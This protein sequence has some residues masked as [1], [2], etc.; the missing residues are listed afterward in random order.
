MAI[1][2]VVACL[3]FVRPWL[4]GVVYGVYTTPMLWIGIPVCVGVLVLA[5]GRIDNS[6]A[7]QAVVVVCIIGVMA[8]SS[9]SGTFA[10]NTLGQ[11]TMQDSQTVDQLRETNASNPRLLTK[12]VADRYAT[13]TL[14]FPQYQISESD[15]TIHNGTPHW[16]YAL[17]PDGLWNHLTKK[18]HGTVMVDMTRQNAGVETI[19]NDLN[20][21]IGTAFYNNY[22][23]HLLKKGEY[24]ANYKD[25]FMVMHEGEQYIAVPYTVPK[26]HWLSIPHTTPTWGGVMLVDASGTVT[27]LSPEEARQHPA[28]KGQKL[29]PFD[30]TRRAV[31]A[32]KYRNG[33]LNTYTS[34]E[35]EIEVA[36]VPGDGNDQPFLL[37]TTQ[38][39]TYVVAAEPY[40]NAQ[41]LNEIWMV[42][43]RTGQHSRYT[44]NTSLFGPRKATNYVRKAA[45]K[46][47][48]DRFTPAEPLP[49][50]IDGQLFWEIRVVPDDNSGISYIAFVNAQSSEVQEVETT[51]AVTNFL[52]NAVVP[53]TP[54]DGRTDEPAPTPSI[55]V[56]RV[57]PNGTVIGTMTVS[58]NE[59]VR[60]VQQNET[61]A[62]TPIENGSA[63]LNAPSM[64]AGPLYS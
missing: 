15:I 43:A 57:A 3:W 30:L 8:L 53:D 64:G 9:V 38:G 61:T 17:A 49:V 36:P 11:A 28:L 54:S 34:H 35:E 48:W 32:T 21:G 2:I 58:D 37:P 23:W 39:P 33:I 50:I 18:Q 42:D 55:I 29:Y 19:A 5:Y 25:P 45:R 31:A 63:S 27:D 20:K 22:K 26:F 24:L 62:G 14:N 16:S 59:S 47:D 12:G 41:G 52:Q 13:N 4:H 6:S 46:T 7:L 51:T 1:F 56:E 40:G 10:A 44:T 60:I